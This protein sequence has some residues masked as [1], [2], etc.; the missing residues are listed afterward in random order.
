[1]EIKLAKARVRN[2]A[3]L[4][5]QSP[6]HTFP[7]LTA[8]LTLFDSLV[9]KNA[10]SLTTASVILCPLLF[11]SPASHFCKKT[12]LD[13]ESLTN[14]IFSR[15]HTAS[16]PYSHF[17]MSYAIDPMQNAWASYVVEFLLL[18]LR[19]ILSICENKHV[20]HC[21]YECIR[22]CKIVQ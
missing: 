13:A 21:N 18:N 8:L 7:L 11:T 10:L 22:K 12:Y 15:V 16:S 3:L 20:I 5:A 17:L 14:L 6:R 1:M 19:D 4:V 2:V 9:I